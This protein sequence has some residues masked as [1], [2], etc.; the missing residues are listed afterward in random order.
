MTKISV[1][2]PVFNGENYINYTIKSLL[3]QTFS[4]FEIICIDDSSTDNS[5]DILRRYALTDDR[6]KIY[7]KK[8]EGSA[9][10]SIKFGL[11]FVSGEYFMYTSQDDF[12]SI[13]LLGKNY[14]RAEETHSDA[15]L[16]DLVFYSGKYQRK[17]VGIHSNRDVVL[18]GKDAFNYSLNWEIHG[19]ALWKTSLIK[20]NFKSD[21]LMVSDEYTY[22]ICFLRS[23]RV[24]FSDGIFFY[25]VNNPNAITKKWNIRLFDYILMHERLFTVIKDYNLSPKN[26]ENNAGALIFNILYVYKIFME[27]FG[28][29][30]IEDRQSIK[31]LFIQ[32]YAKYREFIKYANRISSIDRFLLYYIPSLYKLKCRIKKYL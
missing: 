22:R 5:L 7:T 25:R 13:D 24:A 32:Y 16:P 31:I 29:I 3:A 26:Y 21:D 18:S 15:I 27:S 1:I 9:S 28:G 8:N 30:P 11:Q 4:D 10:K 2:L 20:E 12:F 6:I 23:H 17:Q 19:F 14:L